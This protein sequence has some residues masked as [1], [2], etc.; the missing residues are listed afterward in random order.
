MKMSQLKMAIRE[1]VREEIRLGLK[2]VIGEVK[3]QPVQK[4][5]P[6]QKQNYTKNAVL[7]E[8]LNDTSAEDWETMGGTKYTS[9]RMGEL[10]GNSY[11]DLMNDD[12]VNSNGNL[13]VE[14]GVNPNDPS[15]A[16]LKK[17]YRELMKAVDKKKQQKMGG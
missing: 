1:V 13:A 9:E 4:P 17:D 16:F 14:M 15:A 2:E 7:N 10:V 3:K 5:K 6:K 11:K 12:N 8:V